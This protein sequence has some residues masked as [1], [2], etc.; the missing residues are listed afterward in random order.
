[1]PPAPAALPSLPRLVWQLLPLAFKRGR[2]LSG[3]PAPSIE[4]EDTL[5]VD[6]TWLSAYRDLV[7]ARTDNA[8][9]PCVPHVLAVGLHR[10][11]LADARFPLPVL[12][13]VHV[14]QRIEE[15]RALEPREPLR[16][17]AALTSM[18]PGERGT[19]FDIVTEARCGGELAWRSVLG[20]LVRAPPTA[21]RTPSTR[22][23]A[24]PGLP[25]GTWL[26]SSAL[27]LPAALGRSY[28]RVAGDANPIHLY[29][30]SARAFGFRRPIVHG[31]WTLARA[32]HEVEG[33]WPTW[34]RTFTAQFLRPVSLPGRVVISSSA[35]DPG[36][37]WSIEVSP[38]RPGP[39]HVRIDVSSG[40]ATSSG[41]A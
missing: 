27:R 26:T 18:Q 28:G 36:G 40:V 13:V 15:W 6:P 34:P 35:A 17:H 5:A 24:E 19:R 16:L 8:L 25:A 33:R 10:R 30:W 12:G 39:A 32:L 20:A 29:S 21:P 2:P 22:A 14:E 38:P 4:F 1:M 37:N 31:M 23:P 41:R 11:I 9:P 7:S 3:E